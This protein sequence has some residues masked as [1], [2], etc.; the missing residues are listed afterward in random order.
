MINYFIEQ[1]KGEKQKVNEEL[2]KFKIYELEKVDTQ[3][4]TIVNRDT[5]SGIKT[6]TT[7]TTVQECHEIRITRSFNKM[8]RS[9][10]HTKEE[11][12]DSWD[13]GVIIGTLSLLTLFVAAIDMVCFNERKKARLR[14]ISEHLG[15]EVEEMSLQNWFWGWIEHKWR[16]ILQLITNTIRSRQ[17]GEHR[18]RVEGRQARQERIDWRIDLDRIDDL[19]GRRDALLRNRER[20]MRIIRELSNFSIPEH[21]RRRIEFV[22][23]PDIQGVVAQPPVVHQAN[24]E[25]AAHMQAVDEA[26]N[27]HLRNQRE[28]GEIR[29]EDL[30]IRPSG[31]EI[32][33]ESH[34]SIDI[35]D[36][37]FS[38]EE[39]E[40]K[41]I[42]E[43]ENIEEG[44][45]EIIEQ[46][47][48][49]ENREEEEHREEREQEEEEGG[50]REQQEGEGGQEEEG[51]EGEQEEEGE[52]EEQE[53]E[54]EDREEQEEER[55]EGRQEE[56]IEEVDER[57]ERRE[58]EEKRKD[59]KKRKTT[60]CGKCLIH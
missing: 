53:E 14:R 28:E 39:G 15:R 6:T 50:Q 27:D 10:D 26:R 47:R 43:T 11:L 42:E 1:I 24:P 51:E 34:S 16:P 37:S 5:I 36:F 49:G 22:Q 45:P 52:R 58:Q 13:I 40:G 2:I 21:I 30:V 25:M 35:S 33:D 29:F 48:E 55:E 20:R 59:R 57:E 3:S 4:L 41:I 7:E 31:I 18:E 44:E 56:E 12:N 8:K 54:R 9:S 17:Q 32:M 46:E 19:P 60:T 38:E 23:G